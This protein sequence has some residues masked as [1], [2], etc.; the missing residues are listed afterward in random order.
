[1]SDAPPIKKVWIEEGCISCQRCQDIAPEVFFVA[2]DA[3]CVVRP[4]APQRFDDQS[5][6]IE[7]AAEDCPVEVI[8]VERT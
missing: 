7:Q 4:E 8:Q 5:D 6:E 2:D 3:D 1:M